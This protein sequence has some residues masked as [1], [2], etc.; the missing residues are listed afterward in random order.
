M[1]DILVEDAAFTFRI[2]TAIILDKLSELSTDYINQP[3]KR[4]I[5]RIGIVFIFIS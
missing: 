3:K 5:T 1:T 4:A 2:S